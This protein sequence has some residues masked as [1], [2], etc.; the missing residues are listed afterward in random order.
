MRMIAILAVVATTTTTGCSRAQVDGDQWIIASPHDTLTVADAAAVWASLDEGERTFF[1]E[2]DDPAGSFIDALSG[3][4]AILLLVEDSGMLEDEGLNAMAS[5]WLRVESAMAAR[6]L[7]ADE[8]IAAVNE[9]D[10]R[11]WRE[12]QGVFVML[13]SDSPC[14]KGPFA[15]AELPRELGAALQQISPGE[16]ALLEGFGLVTLDS[17]LRIPGQT[18]SLPDSVVANI[19]GRERERFQYLVEYA[20]IIEEGGT[21][22]SPGF[23]NLSMLPEDSIVLHSPLGQWTRSQIETELE[24]FQSRFPH[25]EASAQWSDMILENLLM[26]SHYRNVLESEHPLVADSLGE[27]ARAYLESQAAE[28]LVRQYL[29]SAVTVTRADLEEEYSMQEEPPLTTEHRVFHLASAGIGSLPELRRAMADGIGLEPYPGVPELASPGGDPRISR[30]LVIAE[31]PGESASILFGID[32]TDTLTWYGPF[33]I[34]Q[35]CFAAF[36]LRE[37]VP[38]RPLTIEEMETQLTRTA[39]HRLEAVATDILIDKLRDRFQVIVNDD[40]LER[41]SPDPAKWGAGV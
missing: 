14:P 33:E 4:E 12:N 17:L 39:R 18:E 10:M 27:A 34:D 2:S 37:V 32:R 41:L 25:V 19:I 11:F 24:F 28:V 15:I 26:Q 5:C 30:P 31:V 38:S 23:A 9:G 36:R 20:R 16:S 3:K 21:G 7:A 22:I 13:S 40:V 6:I 1:A 29:D 35:D 8:E